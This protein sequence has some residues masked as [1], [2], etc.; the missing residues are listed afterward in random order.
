VKL[1]Q[2]STELLYES[3]CV[4]TPIG[5]TMTCRKCVD[6]C[7][8]IIEGRKLPARLAVF[9]MLGFDVIL[10]MDWLLRYDASIDCRKKE[11]TFR[12]PNNDE[13][14]FC[15]SRERATPPLLSAIKAIKSV[16]EGTSTYLDYVQSKPETHPKLEGIPV[17]CNYSDVFSEVVGLPPD[18][19]IE[20]CIDLVPG[21]QPIHKAPYRMA[22]T[23][24]RE[25]K[26]QL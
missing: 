5:N 2:L 13:F 9:N 12:L 4:A 25:L 23:E 3:I 24:L 6:N 21:T 18:R 15:G 20:F 17:V 10:G 19:E 14:K 11:V 22:P 26:E 7:P 1:Y 8:I 16:R